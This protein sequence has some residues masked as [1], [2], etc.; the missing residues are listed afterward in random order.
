MGYRYIKK[1]EMADLYPNSPNIVDAILFDY[2]NFEEVCVFLKNS[3]SVKYFI[4]YVGKYLIIT[5]VEG[6]SNITVIPGEY[7]LD[8]FT[9]METCSQ[10]FFHEIYRKMEAQNE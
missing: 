3:N 9:E 6:M 7:I 4:N 10:G 2:S 1:E 8:G 5:T